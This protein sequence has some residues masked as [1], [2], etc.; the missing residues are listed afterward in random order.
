MFCSGMSTVPSDEKKS[1]IVVL[2]SFGWSLSRIE[3]QTRV[4]HEPTAVCLRAAVIAARKPG[5][6]VSEP[7]TSEEYPPTLVR[8][9]KNNHR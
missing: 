3:E 9:P 4:R 6:L 1:Q 7:A 5:G 2:G 8:H